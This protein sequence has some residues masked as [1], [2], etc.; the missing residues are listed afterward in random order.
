VENVKL[1]EDG[2]AFTGKPVG[3]SNKNGE[4]G[5]FPKNEMLKSQPL[6]KF[7]PWNSCFLPRFISGSGKVL[8]FSPMKKITSLIKHRNYNAIVRRHST[9]Q[10]Y[11]LVKIKETKTRWF[12][13]LKMEM[14]S[15]HAGDHSLLN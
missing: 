6:Y 7:L 13:E 1:F 2:A 5:I 4:P 8:V 14:K 11:N 12:P 15:N 10:R 9:L 3:F